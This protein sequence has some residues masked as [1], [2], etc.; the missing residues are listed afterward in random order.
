MLLLYMSQSWTLLKNSERQLHDVRKTHDQIEQ[1]ARGHD[2][3]S[4]IKQ[5]EPDPESS[6]SSDLIFRLF[7]LTV[8]QVW[9]IQNAYL[10]QIL[11]ERRH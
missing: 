6:S 5:G 10:T 9:G 11:H 4:K 1:C 8:V 2:D 3:G 7:R